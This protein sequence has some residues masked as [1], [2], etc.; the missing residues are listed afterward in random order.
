MTDD[1][2]G[3]RAAAASFGE[4]ASA[5]VDSRVHRIG[6]DLERLSGWCADAGC[7]LDVATGAGHTASAIFDH[8]VERVVAADAAPDMVET[9]MDVNAGLDGVVA[10]AEDLPFA[11][12]AFD[13]VAC[14]IAA[15]HFPDPGAFVREVARVTGDGGTFAFEDNIAPADDDLDAFLN[16][17]ERL[18]DP[19]H[20]RSHR[21]SAWVEW[22]E[23]AGFTV[24]ETRVVKKE[25]GYESWVEQLD[26]PEENRRELRARFAD[27]PEGAAE[28]YEITHEDGDVVSFSNLKILVRATR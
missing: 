19:T 23:A 4:H 13:A 7:A 17:V 18:R 27:P 12:D 2:N 28:L 16:D 21:E 5:Y 26:T 10:G 3:K 11:D 9:A 20:H 14:R 6:D 22:I 25:I 24:E 15:H 8:G 1:T